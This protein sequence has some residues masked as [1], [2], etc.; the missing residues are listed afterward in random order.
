MRALKLVDDNPFAIRKNLIMN[1]C[2]WNRGTTI[3]LRLSHKIILSML[4][5]VL[6]LSCRTESIFN[7]LSENYLPYDSVNSVWKYNVMGQDTVT[8]EWDISAR[9][10]MGGREASLVESTE[11][12]FYY[13]TD[14]AGLN[15][16]VSQTVLSFG[17][18]VVLEER[19]RQRVVK[20]LNLGNRWEDN[21]SNQV[22]HQGAAYT[23]ESSLTGVVE[24]IETVF[25]PVD[26]FDECYRVRIDTY[27]K[28]TLTTGGV[29]EETVH[30]PE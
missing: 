27:Y 8:V 4:P 9:E 16:F 23:I 2:K 6:L 28:I 12:N 17:E 22:V 11:G 26:F 5:L 25:T 13:S 10:V 15:E 20:P 14:Q 18:E 7:R 1:E 3:S 29:D 24:D 21:F 30:M 19:W